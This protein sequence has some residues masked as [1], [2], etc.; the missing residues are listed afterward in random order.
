MTISSPPKLIALHKW[1]WP[2]GVLVAGIL[3]SAHAGLATAQQDTVPVIRLGEIVVE[4]AAGA[5]SRATVHTVRR[6]ELAKIA[7]LDAAVVSDFARLIPAAYIQTNSRGETLI[8]LRNAGDR[9]VGVFFE[10][11]LLNIPW[12]NRVDMSL[13]PASAIGGISVAKGVPPV[14]YG[15]NVL[16]GA[17]NLTAR[18]LDTPYSQTEIVSR[19]GTEARVGGSITHQRRSGRVTYMG[20]VAYTKVDGLALPSDVVFSFNQADPDLRTNSDSRVTNVFAAATYEFNRST[21]GL[22]LLHMDAAKGVAPESHLNPAVSRVRFWRYPKWRNTVAVVSGQGNI[23]DATGWKG[24]AWVNVFSQQIDSYESAAYDRF[25][26]REEDD[27]LTFGSRFVVS[28]PLGTSLLKFSFNG[29]TST[30]EQTDTDLQPISGLAVVGQTFPRLRYQQHLFSVGT[31]YTLNPSAS[32]LVTVGASYDRMFTPKTGDKPGHSGFADYSTTLGATY[33]GGGE[34]GGG[35]FVRGAIGRKARFPT[36]RELFGDALN[37]FLLNPDLGTESSILTE[38]GVGVEGEHVSGE[39]IPFGTFT[40]GTIDQQSV[41]VPGETQARRQRINLK[42]SRVLGVEM[43]GTVRASDA[44]SFDGH[45]TLMS[46]HRLRDSANEPDRL[47]EKPAALGRLAMTYH[48]NGGTGLVLETVYTGRAYSLNDANDFVPLETSLVFNLRVSQT[49]HVSSWQTIE[50]F[51]R[52]DNVT[53]TLV[54]PQLGIPAA[55]RTMSGG[56]KL[57]L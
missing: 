40:S 5:T 43:V 25:D 4:A 19:F 52:A 29:L 38:I 6:V 21:L 53:D 55:G 31:E 12:D 7:M 30:H 44:I 11:A 17:V 50:L 56:A 9:Q 46:V 39:I 2:R 41:L 1:V 10:G 42:G 24:S 54:L 22:S 45:L 13:I 36:M 20:S 27:D 37:R 34:N 47:S 23:G 35:W 8:Y 32:L 14:E 3:S 16:G 57:T 28:Q 33:D 26:A 51:V 49:L 48:T 18:T 15:T